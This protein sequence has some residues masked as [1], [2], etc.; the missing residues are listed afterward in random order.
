M[1][2]IIAVNGY[3]ANPDLLKRRFAEGGYRL[4]ETAHFLLFTRQKRWMRTSAITFC[5]N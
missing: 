1:G 5:A 2:D 3:R 4:R